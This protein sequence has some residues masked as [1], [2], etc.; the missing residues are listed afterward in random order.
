MKSGDGRLAFL[1]RPADP[2][3][4]RLEVIAEPLER[5]ATFLNEADGLAAAG[6]APLHV[7]P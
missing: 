1:V 5:C 6:D 4:D 2:R 3:Y 7:L